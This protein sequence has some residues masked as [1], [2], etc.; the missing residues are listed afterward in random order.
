MAGIAGNDFKRLCLEAGLNKAAQDQD[1]YMILFKNDYTPAADDV[2]ADYT[3][4]TFS[5]YAPKSL[6]GS[7]WAVTTAEPA[8]A[9]YAEQEFISDDDQ[10][11]ETIYGYAIFLDTDDTFVGGERFSSPQVIQ[12]NLDQIAVTPRLRLYQKV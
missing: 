12:N 4:A 8:V 6:T 2:F 1:Q 5:G 9:S 10:T 7:S 11:P 3:P